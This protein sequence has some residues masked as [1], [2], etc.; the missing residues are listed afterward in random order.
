MDARLAPLDP[1]RTDAPPAPGS[2]RYASI[3]ERA[4]S[5]NDTATTTL[6]PIAERP[7]RAHRRRPYLGAAAAAALVAVAV[8]AA[9]LGSGADDP[10]PISVVSSAAENTGEVTSLRASFEEETDYRVTTG[11][12]EVN[13]DGWS[14][15]AS[16]TFKQ[17][18]HVERETTV[19]IGPH[20]WQ[21]LPDGSTHSTPAGGRGKSFGSSS[22]AVV[23]AALSG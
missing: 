2:A 13:G 5:D 9:L 19:V 16:S 20:A 10:D 11:A 7:R 22:Q 1:S 6:A 3:L 18:G 4:M 14:W 23:A 17:D 21:K 8:S 12:I 15:R